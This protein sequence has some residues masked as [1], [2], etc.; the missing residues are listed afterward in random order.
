MIVTHELILEGMS[1]NGGWNA[2]QFALLGIAWP[3]FHGW[4][5]SVIGQEI[6]E[7]DAAEFVRLRGI[8]KKREAEFDLDAEMSRRLDR[9]L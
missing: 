9:D 8:T 6:S 4:K 5:Y 2:K 3:P 1:G 7:E